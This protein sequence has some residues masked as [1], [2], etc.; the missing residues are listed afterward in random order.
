M[1][2]EGATESEARQITEDYLSNF[3]ITG[4]TITVQNAYKGGGEGANARQVVVEAEM[5]SSSA[6]ILGDVLNVFGTS[7]LQI[8]VS[9]RKEG[10]LVAAP[11][12]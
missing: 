9:M 12:N 4:A 11:V 3:G 10:E 2:I 6:S 7:K 5:P 8:R 1:A